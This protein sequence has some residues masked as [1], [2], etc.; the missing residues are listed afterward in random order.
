[1]KKTTE[2]GGK[3]KTEVKKWVLLDPSWRRGKEQLL[4]F[5]S[6]VWKAFFLRVPM[7]VQVWYSVKLIVFPRFTHCLVSL[8]ANLAAIPLNIVIDF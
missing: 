6:V 2:D 3:K 4:C 1:M 7:L 5:Y 8:G